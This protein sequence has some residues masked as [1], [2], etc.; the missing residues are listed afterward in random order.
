MKVVLESSSLFFNNYTGIPFYILNL[1]Q[2]L[3]QNNDIEPV[4]GFRLKKRFQKKSDLQIEILKNNHIWH[5][6]NLVL[7]KQKID[8]A[9]SLHTPFLNPSKTL[10]VAT[11]HDLAVHLPEFKEYDFASEYFKNKRLHLFKEFSKKA[12]ALIT[13]SQSTKADFL[14]FFDFP[15]EDIHVVPLA[16]SRFS[17][18][19]TTT[20]HPIILNKLNLKR[21]EYFLFV[22]GVSLRKNTLN[23]IK[24]YHQSASNIDTKLVITGK[25]QE[26][27]QS[28]VIK[29]IVKHQ[30][31]EKVVIT[32]YLKKSEVQFLYEHAKAFLFPTF[33]EGFGIPI[34]EAMHHG[35][36]VLTS[37]TGAAPE[38]AGEHAVLVDPFSPESIGDGIE[39]VAN[40][41][42]S[43]LAKAKKYAELFT[44]ERTAK[45]TADV[46][47][48]YI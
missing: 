31:G 12:D 8:V 35:L 21:K 5:Q 2:S 36:P 23:L 14:K 34:L 37:N 6:N 19:K 4:L 25:I 40:I 20:D 32:D 17:I 24:G 11:V 13:V 1:Y 3:S 15:E 43:L 18:T 48:K 30:L 42:Q 9:H 38:S 41:D 39:K 28:E 29:Y 46:Y 22:G 47:K 10:K 44:W 7:S 16:P 33:Y 26:S 27:F 45:M